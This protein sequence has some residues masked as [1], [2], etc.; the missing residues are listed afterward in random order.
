MEGEI[1]L[2]KQTERRKRDGGR[3]RLSEREIEV[4]HRVVF[5]L[6][7]FIYIERGR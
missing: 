1:E 2:G 3:E 4:D 7:C 6:E 5:K